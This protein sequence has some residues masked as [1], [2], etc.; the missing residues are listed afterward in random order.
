FESL[1]VAKAWQPTLTGAGMPERLEGQRVTAAYFD[2]LRVPPALGRALQPEDDRRGGPNV[3][4][5]SDALWRRRFA[6]DSAIAGR[7]GRLDDTAYTVIGVTP[8]GFAD[9]QA[10]SI[11]IWSALQYDMSL[12]AAWGHHLRTIGRLR[13]DAAVDRAS[14][15]VD[16]AGRAVLD[17]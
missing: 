11:Q 14:K 5:L 10:P 8:P 7:V 16:A 1:A 6:S 4:V 13:P 9:A 3:A 17:D 15:E 12:G 2:V